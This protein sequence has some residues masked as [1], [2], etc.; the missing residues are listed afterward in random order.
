MIQHTVLNWD[1]TP[2]VEEREIGPGKG[3][4][5][6]DDVENHSGQSTSQKNSNSNPE[7]QEDPVS[8]DDLIMKVADK[9]TH[10]NK[11]KIKLN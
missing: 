2:S 6:H 9:V 3:W 7:E 10:H 11:K 8:L 1:T 5:D 4:S